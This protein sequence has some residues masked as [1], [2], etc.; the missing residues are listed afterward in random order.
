MTDTML[1]RPTSRRAGS[2]ARRGSVFVALLRSPVGLA[3]ILLLAICL[4]ATVFGP[5]LYRV[6]PI[7]IVGRPLLPPGAPGAPPLG[8]DEVGRD[9]LAGLLNGGR[10]TLLV[11]VAAAALSTLIGVVIG[12]LAGYLGGW[13][14]S[15][16][17]RF[18]E[19]FQVLPILL[20]AMVL[21]TLFQP[22]VGM[23]SFAIGIVAW[24]GTA[25]ITRAEFMR[26]RTL[27]YVRAARAIGTKN[28]RIML[29]LV[30]PNALPPIIVISTLVVGSAMLFE[31]GLSFLGLGAPGTVSWGTMLGDNRDK[32]A[33]AWWT[34]TLP[35][36]AIF[37][38]VVSIS[39]IGDGLNDA[40]NPKRRKR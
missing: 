8:T 7:E 26:I 9:L 34:V 17:M 14:D 24:P 11:G 5:M 3:G 19:F 12:G 2:P 22:S 4:L 10:V 37:L 1:P 38:A 33:I 30:L 6:D 15:A 35:G 29:R 27:D 16:L 20:F 32:L 28:L 21:V 31:S 18:T 25:R 40:L 13:I 39:L 36:A 23:L